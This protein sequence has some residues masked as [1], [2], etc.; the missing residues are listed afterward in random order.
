MNAAR[1]ARRYE[2]YIDGAVVAPVSGE[3]LPTENPYTGKA[4]AQI[5]RGKRDDVEAAVAAAQ[6]R[7]RKRR[8]GRR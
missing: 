1:I 4:W 6:P 5:A 2:H 8:R 7:L 3:Y